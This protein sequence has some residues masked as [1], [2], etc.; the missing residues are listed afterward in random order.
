M[1]LFDT[2]ID[3]LET[4]VGLGGRAA[5]LLRAV[6]R[7][8]EGHQGGLAGF[9][10]EVRAAGLDALVPGWLGRPDAPAITAP[11]AR[12][13]FGD[14][15]D[16]IAREAGLTAE[17]TAE[18]LAYALPKL[19][20]LLTPDR[21]VPAF[22]PPA[23]AAF[24]GGTAG[25][26]ASAT[27]A[28][29]TT[30]AAGGAG[31]WA[32]PLVAAL[33][34]LG[35]LW[36]WFAGRGEEPTRTASAPPP[37]SPATP[38]SPFATESRLSAAP[39][40]ATEQAAAPPP[41]APSPAPTT[42]APPAA[43]TAAPPAAT[44]AA[45]PAATTS[46]PG[47]PA[48]P[49]RLAVEQ[50]ADGIAVSGTVPDAG[51]RDAVLAALREAFGGGAPRGD[52]TVD[53]AAAPPA[54]LPRLQRLLAEA[55]QVGVSLL[56]EGDT[57]AVGGDAPPAERDRV[58]AALR[59]LVGGALRVGPMPDEGEMVEASGRQAV[60][61]LGT[62]PQD[63][64]AAAISAV[65]DRAII[66][67]DTASA[68]V[69]EGARALLAAAAERLRQLPA[70][71]RIEV[72]GHTDSTGDAALNRQLSERRAEAVVAALVRDGVPEAMLTARGYGSEEPAASNETADGRFRNRRISF[73]VLP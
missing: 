52:I 26:A 43:T 29:T 15:I 53:P 7:T 21:V 64:T 31:R 23:A 67:F 68:E 58:I 49:S 10:D 9:L 20:G 63:T 50:G 39:P 22:L 45:P 3:E 14:G 66:N 62:L 73:R 51:T 17:R 55:R 33:L 46:A 30:A 5:P 54:W 1:A 38:A 36:Y 59:A 11:Q 6:L 25:T 42:T 41:A 48:P 8:I 65:L 40:T 4:H 2:L 72:G 32:L 69:P 35:G 47:I 27:T 16:G 19:V 61:A 71:T 18:A 24:L 57:V 37:A 60:A 56:L 12:A 28:A 34:V 44:T 70:G 13:A